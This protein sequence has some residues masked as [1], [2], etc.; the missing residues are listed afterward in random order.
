[1]QRLLEVSKFRNLGFEKPDTL[2]LNNSIKKGEIGGLVTL[3]G[4]NNAGKSNVLTALAEIGSDFK[5]TDKDV[6]YLSFDPKDRVPK[7]SLIYRDGEHYIEISR[8]Y[9]KDVSVQYNLPDI[10][11][12][13]LTTIRKEIREFEKELPENYGATLIDVNKCITAICSPNGGKDEAIR[14]FTKLVTIIQNYQNAYSPY[15]RAPA[16]NTAI[17]AFN[18]FKET[19]ET[20]AYYLLKNEKSSIKT[21]NAFL[22][23]FSLNA[24]P[25]IVYY[26]ERNVSEGDLQVGGVSDINDE[27]FFGK[28][29]SILA[30][31]TKEIQETY[32]EYSKHPN[33]AILRKEEKKLN[34]KMKA[35]NNRFNKLY[36]AEKDAYKFEITLES[37]KILFS[38]SRGEGEEE[39]PIMLDSQSTGFKWFFNLYFNFLGKNKL[40]NG[41]I[42]ILDEAGYALH[43][44]GLRELRKFLVEYG[45][46]TGITFVIATHN[47]FLLDPDYYEELRVVSIRDSKAYVDNLFSAI[48]DHDPDSLLPI[49]ESLTIKQNVLYDFDTEVCWVEGITDYCYLTMFKKLLNEENISFLPL[50]GVGRTK[51]ST[52]LILKKLI[53]IKFFNR[54]ILVDG[55]KAGMD[56]FNQCAGTAFDMARHNIGELSDKEHKFISI[57]DLFSE[58]DKK[59]YPATNYKKQ[60]EYKKFYLVS[61]MKNNCKLSDFS[62]ET[63]NNFKKLFK[64]IKD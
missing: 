4:Q 47:P 43:P 52:S 36:F 33:P 11:E 3:I 8:E 20:Y 58:E 53:K 1:M 41:D 55:D 38:M 7:I 10:K 39:N 35:V 13:S 48:N 44:E 25:N 24:I 15:G 16:V 64:L 22:S 50:N 62:E 17:T 6:T 27:T 57:E 2:I 32:N 26:K 34:N 23:Q 21:C 61:V 45:K 31:D 29:L 51:E 9:G 18:R 56:M 30:V 28:L 37:S 46:K 12:P 5:I 59:K 14:Y 40:K 19:S 42:V 49:K 63:I 54:S 60:D